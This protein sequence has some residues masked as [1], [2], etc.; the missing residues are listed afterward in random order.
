MSGDARDLT[1][2]ANDVEVERFHRVHAS[3]CAAHE[4]AGGFGGD[5]DR[6]AARQGESGGLRTARRGAGSA[7]FMQ[8][9]ERTGLLRAESEPVTAHAALRAAVRP[10]R[11]PSM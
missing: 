10:C 5:R 9:L 1:Y 2:R 4:N 7:R 8:P 6:P 3:A 11:A